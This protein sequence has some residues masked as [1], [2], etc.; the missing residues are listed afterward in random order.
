MF[1]RSSRNSTIRPVELGRR[2]LREMDDQR[3]VDVKGRRIV[4][5]MFTFHLSPR[6]HAGF[7]DIED[8]LIH[9]L[10]EAAREY[11]RDE[12][13]HFVGP[14]GVEIVVDN[15]LKPGRFGVASVLRE[16]APEPVSVA[17][18]DAGAGEADAGFAIVEEPRVSPPAAAPAP[19]EPPMVERPP[20]YAPAAEPPQPATPPVYTAVPDAPPVPP[21][22]GSAVGRLQLPSGEK[23]TVGHRVVSIGR[24]PECTV[25]LSD[26]NVSRRHAEVRPGSQL[27]I[28]DLGSTNGTKVNGL[29]IDG[30]RVLVD[31][32]IISLGSSHLRF[33]ASNAPA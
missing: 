26:P 8:A 15:A 24:L 17:A 23:V 14:V 25:T 27:M 16:G 32:D 9:E 6:D 28:V 33:E 13:Y 4:P 1:S 31:G 29:R 3:S 11:A 2:L 19:A 18:G 5:N 20:A 12:G 7:A 10:G 22:I 30:E 21:R